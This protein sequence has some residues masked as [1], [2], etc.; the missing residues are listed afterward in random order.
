MFI[1]TKMFVYLIKK[2]EKMKRVISFLLVVLVFMI[3]IPVVQAKE[4]NEIY[5]YNGEAKEIGNITKIPES[6]VCVEK[7]S[8]T[9]IR[10]THVG[11]VSIYINHKKKSLVIIPKVL[12]NPKIKA[13]KE[14]DKVYFVYQESKG[15]GFVTVYNINPYNV[16]VEINDHTVKNLYIGVTYTFALTRQEFDTMTPVVTKSDLDVSDCI[17]C[18]AYKNKIHLEN[19]DDRTCFAKVSYLILKNNKIIKAVEETVQIYGTQYTDIEPELEDGESIK[20][21]SL[22]G[23]IE[24]F[25]KREK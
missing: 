16:T 22:T 17:S 15:K 11:K 3:S 14:K 19:D 2:G 4:K 6:N 7:L 1:E 10:A 12:S 18:K 8:K 9:K 21:L 23:W 5:M 20:Y 24:N 25:D 13:A